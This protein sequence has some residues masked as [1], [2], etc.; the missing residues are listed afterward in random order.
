MGAGFDQP[1]RTQHMDGIGVADGG[2]PVGDHDQGLAARPC[3]QG[4]LHRALALGVQRR[5]RLV[6]DP[7]RRVL[8]QGPRNR[9]TLA[10]P[11]RELAAVGADRR[12][13]PFGQALHEIPQ[14]GGA[15]RGLEPRLVARLGVGD[16]VGDRFVEQHDVLRHHGELPA[17]AQARQR[18]DVDA[19]QAD[20]PGLR[21]AEAQQ[22]MD[23]GALAGARGSDQGRGAAGREA[24]AQAV[25]G[26]LARAGVG[27]RDRFDA[28]I[29]MGR[30]GQL[31]A[32]AVQFLAGI[33]QVEAAVGNHQR[34]GHRRGQVGQVAQPGGQQQQRGDKL[35]KVAD[36]GAGVTGL[37]QR[38]ADDG[39]Q[40]DR[41]DQLR[42]RLAQRAG[43]GR[44]QRGPAH[45]LRQRREALQLVLGR[46]ELPH[47]APG[48][49]D[50][51]HTVYQGQLGVVGTR[52]HLAH[53]L[54]D[55]LHHQGHQRRDH[56]AQQRE[57]PVHV[58]EVDQHR[59]GRQAVAQHI[60]ADLAHQLQ[61]L[62]RVV[63]DLADRGAR[64]HAR[65]DLGVQPQQRI[66]QGRAEIH[67]AAGYRPVEQ[68]LAREAERAADDVEPDQHD[69]H[70]PQIEGVLCEALA[71]CVLDQLGN[72]GL[73][74][75]QAH[76]GQDRPH[77][78][79][80]VRIDELAEAPGR[81]DVAGRHGVRLSLGCLITL[82]AHAP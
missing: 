79:P 54:I 1:A 12:L 45:L 73:G 70:H 21:P 2:E 58:K 19:V 34:T 28:D 31:A 64:L 75:G 8:V 59:D 4:L 52:G 78:A 81:G 62:L 9:Q 69:R 43:R 44:L 14:M 7:D 3:I 26:G 57:L 6:K 47:H 49:R 37:P 16:V 66:D 27:E 60:D 51:V 71:E 48:A 20:A 63:D 38:D 22:Q 68:V 55:L 67:H 76:I 15:Q 72:R 5:G 25:E 18:L 53:A 65:V 11:A 46:A 39:R 77:D 30:A 42:Q 41:G 82:R 23:D 56:E 74:G 33:E 10:L 24:Q 80:A 35:G 50:V 29:A 32:A 13:D 17:Q 40:P 61:D 36:A